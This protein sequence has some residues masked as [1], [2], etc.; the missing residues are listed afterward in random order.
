[1]P[2]KFHGQGSLED[3]SP[4]ACKDSDMTELAHKARMIKVYTIKHKATTKMT[5]QEVTA[6]KE[7]MEIKLYKIFN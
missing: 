4:W 6:N 7:I 3:Y 5:K 2:G 1:M